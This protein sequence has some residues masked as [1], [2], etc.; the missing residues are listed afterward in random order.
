MPRAFDRGIPDV[1]KNPLRSGTDFNDPEGIIGSGATEAAGILG[2][3]FRDF[4]GLDQ[5]D[6]AFAEFVGQFADINWASPEAV[7]TVIAAAGELLADIGRWALTLFQHFT[8]LDLSE[9]GQFVA[10]LLALLAFDVLQGAWETF[11]NGWTAL[12]WE[13]PLT[14]MHPGWML[15]VDFG[16]DIAGWLGQLVD[17]I[18][19]ISL[20]GFLALDALRGHWTDFFTTWGSISWAS[21]LTA[22]HAAWMALVDLAWNLW[23]WFLTVLRN[24]TGI[25]L[26]SFLDIDTLKGL[27]HDFEDAWAAINWLSLT[28]LW[29][30]LR[31]IG[32]LLRGLTHWLIGVFQNLT[33]IDLHGIAD[34]FGITALVA[35]LTAWATTLAGIDWGDPIPGLMTAIGAFITLAQDLGNW[36]L[37]VIESWLGWGV[38][39]V[40]DMFSDFG[41]FVQRV[42]E[43]FWGGTAVA[44]WIRTIEALAGEAGASITDAIRAIYNEAERIVGLIGSFTGLSQLVDFV[45]AILGPDGLLGWLRSIP[46]IGPLV[47]AL[48][49]MTPGEGAALDLSQLGVWARGLLDKKSPLPAENI[50]GQIGEALLGLV[51]VAHI[52]DASPNLLS[53]GEFRNAATINGGDGWEWDPT[54]GDPDA[55][56]RKGCAKLTTAGAGNPRWLYSTQA[57]RVG[58]GDRV[59]VSA[60]VKTSGYDGN[61]SSIVLSVIPYIGTTAQ[62]E[63]VFASRGSSTSWVDLTGTAGDV[64]PYVV[65][66]DVTSLIVKLGVNGNSGTAGSSVWFD[67]LSL[68]K[69][70]GLQQTL[71]D[72]LVAAWNELHRGLT[73]PLGSPTTNKTWEDLFGAASGFRGLFNTEESKGQ[74]LR[75]KMFGDPG[76][77]GTQAN[78]GFIPNITRGKSTDM[79]TIIN[80]IWRGLR[81]ESTEDY[82]AAD[83]YNA[84]F[85][86]QESV[87]K[88]KAAVA[89]LVSKTASGD[90][91]GVAVAVDFSTLSNASTLPSG[92]WD[93]TNASL[94]SPTGTGTLGTSGGRAKWIASAADNRRTISIHKTATN[95]YYQMISV[96]FA[97][98]VNSN[99]AANYIF[100]R[101]NSTG[102]TAVYVKFTA[103][104]AE[105]WK[106]T[107]GTHT[108]IGV[109]EWNVSGGDFIFYQGGTYKLQCG[110]VGEEDRFKV[111]QDGRVVINVSDGSAPKSHKGAG[112]GA[113]ARTYT[114]GGSTRQALPAEAA[115]F[116][117]Y[118][119]TPSATL[120]SGFHIGR[121]GTTPEA[122]STNTSGGVIPASF[123]GSTPSRKSDDLTWDNATN[124]VTASVAGWYMVTVSL[125]R[126]MTS[127]TDRN[128][129][130]AIILNGSV[131]AIGQQQWNFTAAWAATANATGTGSR[132]TSVIS[133]PVYIGKNEH[134]QAGYISNTSGDLV[135]TEIESFFSVAFL[136][137]TK[138]VQPAAA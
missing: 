100:G 90:F 9:Y 29:D 56:I 109:N 71:V 10:D 116:T 94:G 82:T 107:S 136:G 35:A 25:E 69:E 76:T 37:G 18:L 16:W 103:F 101:S 6:E 138:P 121:A 92:S 115:A 51:P 54:V 62:T 1:D 38:S 87:A 134:V 88:A 129:A 78:L 114:A 3:V 52:S 75:L 124:K 14:A 105:L 50:F 55:A 27:W 96:V 122:Y 67:N 66:A 44:G 112:I 68:T 15:L 40:H 117:F 2:Q 77:V 26:P 58:T 22:I 79:Q 49:G 97:T 126:V 47:G 72:K 20:P 36:L 5:L 128:F 104:K 113:D 95:T 80:N 12:D 4:L 43:Y 13:N 106:V 46:L 133:M 33:G 31:A 93:N 41:T 30:A 83:V 42:I 45:S 89:D 17:N 24:L 110:A 120:G 91:S 28:A 86:T 131:H 8:R 32:S 21:P 102:A 98:N 70:G 127:N 85:Y 73:N 61:G 11:A 108:R 111:W 84:A 74:D 125:R 99:G 81:G 119:N 59:R 65:P 123:F 39:V 118:D 135:G 60:R 137:N 7:R 19:G 23:D 53:Q 132:H 48:T 57:I 64:A 63:K 130:A 34:S